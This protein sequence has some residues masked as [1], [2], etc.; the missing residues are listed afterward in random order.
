VDGLFVSN[1]AALV[2]NAA[3]AG[4]AWCISE[5]QVQKHLERGELAWIVK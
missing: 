3:L 4:L 5:Q 2:L 1:V